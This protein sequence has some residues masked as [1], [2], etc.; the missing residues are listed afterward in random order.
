M[1]VPIPLGQPTFSGAP[2]CADLAARLT[3]N[4]I[5][6]LVRQVRVGSA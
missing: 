5:G 3:L 2:R 6:A 4:L 1:I